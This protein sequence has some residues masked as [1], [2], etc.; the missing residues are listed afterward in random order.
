MAALRSLEAESVFCEQMVEHAEAASFGNR[1]DRDRLWLWQQRLRATRAALVG[2]D[3]TSSHVVAQPRL[4]GGSN[5]PSTPRPTSPAPLAAHPPK[6]PA[7][8]KNTAPAPT[9]FDKEAAA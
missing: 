8:P 6:V 1:W 9:L 5:P 7:Q 3:G 2:R 4:S